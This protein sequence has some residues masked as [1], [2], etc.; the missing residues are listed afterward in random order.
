MAA[1]RFLDAMRDRPLL[2]DSG[3]GTRL[4]AE[5]LDCTSSLAHLNL[6]LPRLVWLNHQDD[7]DAGSDAILANTFQGDRPALRRAGKPSDF[8]AVNREGVVLAREAAGRDR[9]VI[10]SIAPIWGPDATPGDYREQAEVLVDAGCDALMLETHNIEG[11]TR[12]LEAL[13]TIR[14]TIPVMASLWLWP[15]DAKQ[16][17]HRLQDAGAAAIGTNCGEG[18]DDVIAATA[19]ISG[20]VFLPLIAKPSA[21]KPDRQPATPEAFARAVPGLIEM[22]VRLIGGCCGTTPAHVAA[23]RQ[24]LGPQRLA[25]PSRSTSL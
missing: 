11:A 21:G 12:A 10:G 17:A 22:G 1:S 16:A 18:L 20:A 24:A 14:E 2:L 19:R 25:N 3:M 4:M 13:A 23:L 8:F 15:P 6:T 5:A 9:F 7:I